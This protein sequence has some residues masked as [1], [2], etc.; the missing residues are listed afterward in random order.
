MELRTSL[1]MWSSVQFCIIGTT[2]DE[3]FGYIEFKCSTKYRTLEHRYPSIVF[4]PREG[5]ATEEIDYVKNNANAFEMFGQR[6]RQGRR[7]QAHVLPAQPVAR[8]SRRW[9]RLR[10]AEPVHHST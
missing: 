3:L 2:E 7:T 4:R 1:E 6:K 8:T 5:T 9:K 10:L